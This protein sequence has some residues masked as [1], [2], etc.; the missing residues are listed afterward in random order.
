MIHLIN[1]KGPCLGGVFAHAAVANWK[2]T[3]LNLCSMQGLT[4]KNIRV[5]KERG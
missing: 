2:V 4:E 1:D 5:K 3:P